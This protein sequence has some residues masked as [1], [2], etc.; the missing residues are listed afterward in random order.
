[1]IPVTRTA[2]ITAT[3][4]QRKQVRAMTLL[5]K[6]LAHAVLFIGAVTMVIPMLWMISTSLKDEGTIFTYPLHWIPNPIV[7]GNYARLFQVEPFALY[8]G[9]SFVYAVLATIG[10]LLT[11]SMAAYAFARLRF[12]GR[13]LIFMALL[14][15]L[16][17]PDQVTIIPT[18]II[19]KYLGWVDSL[20]PLI[21][22]GW[23][24]GAFGTFLLRQFFLTIPSE[25]MDAAKIDGCSFYGIYAR[26]FMPLAG[27][28]LAT[29]GVFTFM[30]SWNDLFGP[31]IY[32]NTPSKYTVSIGL[33]FFQSVH[34]NSWALLMA[35][36]IVSLVPIIILYVVAQRYFVQG[37]ATTGLKH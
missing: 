14:A 28:A 7:W 16:M 19:M 35:G 29:L 24:G 4:A 30:W 10:Q 1:M 33:T 8:L 12:P 15:T 17:I 31:L 34:Y 2:T 23:A 36:S 37:I 3:K 25:L 6:G 11:C 20:K 22:P 32:L 27:P 21:I 9:N 5:R 13:N 26:I 18:F